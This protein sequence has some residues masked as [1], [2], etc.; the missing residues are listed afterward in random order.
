[1]RATST[2]CP[3]PGTEQMFIK[4]C[5]HKQE[6]FQED[7]ASRFINFDNQN[8]LCMKVFNLKVDFKEFKNHH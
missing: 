1:M 4:S 7:S 6:R 2:K 3:L 8:L 5:P